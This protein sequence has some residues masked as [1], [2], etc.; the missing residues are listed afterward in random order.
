MVFIRATPYYNYNAIKFYKMR[1]QLD[2]LKERLKWIRS[3]IRYSKHMDATDDKL[4]KQLLDT[5]MR[6]I[7]TINNIR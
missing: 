1:T 4:Y 3:C 5:E 7:S 2:D 6:I